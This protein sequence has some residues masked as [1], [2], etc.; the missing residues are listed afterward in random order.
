METSESMID[1]V[2][3][4]RITFVPCTTLEQ[5]LQSIISPLQLAPDHG[6]AIYN[7]TIQ[8]V[9]QH[10]VPGCDQCIV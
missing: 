9:G 8:I 10:L 3:V 7:Q 1:R 4:P 5:N 2:S 6:R